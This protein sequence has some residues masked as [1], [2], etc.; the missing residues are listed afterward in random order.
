MSFTK[1]AAK[2]KEEEWTSVKAEDSEGKRRDPLLEEQLLVLGVGLRV[3]L[4][5]LV[6]DERHI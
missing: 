5:R 4:E 2:L 1:T 3:L 6:L